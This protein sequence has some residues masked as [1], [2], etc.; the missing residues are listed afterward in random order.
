MKRFYCTICRK[1]KRVQ[2]FPPSVRNRDAANPEERQGFCRKHIDSV[3]VAG[4]KVAK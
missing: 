2:T 3:Y 4:R 1:L